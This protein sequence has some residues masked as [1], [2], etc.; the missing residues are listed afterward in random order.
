MLPDILANAG[1]VT[2]SYFEWVQNLENQQWELDE[3][4][5][6]LLK[7]MN[8]AVDLSVERLKSLTA[9]EGAHSEDGHAYPLDLRTA[10]L[11]IAL[12]KLVTVTAQRGIWP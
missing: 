6:K 7:K 10:A 3:V 5:D 9:E 11:V 1:G 12:D 8:R 2:V 4:N